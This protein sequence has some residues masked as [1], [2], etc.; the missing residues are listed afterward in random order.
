MDREMAGLDSAV[1]VLIEESS[2]SLI[3]T[4]RSQQLKN[5]PG[6]IC[7]PGGRWQAGDSD[8]YHTALREL[9][10]EL[11][12]DAGRVYSERPLTMERTL[13]GFIIHPWLA[14]IKT[15]T[16]CRLD[17][18]EV[19]EVFRTPLSQVCKKANYQFIPVEREG[20]VFESCRYLG[21][22]DRFVWGATARIMMQLC[23]LDLTN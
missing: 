11:G 4:Q 23:A 2:Q 14:R 7:F 12:I 19:A 10:E 18:Q 8:L 16:P 13:T 21:E 20:L 9:W 5:H 3:L 22:P 1:M 6:E 15:L 17:N